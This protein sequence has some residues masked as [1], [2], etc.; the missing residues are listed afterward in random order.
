MY[1][2]ILT[3]HIL[4]ATIWTGG[5][6]LLALTI[7]PRAFRERSV[8]ELLRFER[9][10]EKIGIPALA[11][12]IGSGLW[13]AHRLVP[14]TAQWL[15]FEL[16]MARPIGIKLGLIAVTL[17]L[18]AHARTRVLPRLTFERLGLLTWHIVPV[19]VFSVLYVIVGVSF[20]TGWFS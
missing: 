14:D 18:A 12:Q 17:V 15:A 13:L 3:L 10:Y 20:R 7:L 6:L 16:P 8:T 19:T 1:G 5:H 4:G 11:I 9:G 2:I